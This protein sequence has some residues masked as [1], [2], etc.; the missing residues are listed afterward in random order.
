M[1]SSHGLIVS[2]AVTPLKLQLSGKDV[3]LPAV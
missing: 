1:G 3:T 2:W